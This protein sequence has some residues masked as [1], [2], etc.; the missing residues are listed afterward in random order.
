MIII[1]DKKDSLFLKVTLSL[2]FEVG[3]YCYT[4]AHKINIFAT[5]AKEKARILQPLYNDLKENQPKHLRNNN[6]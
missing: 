2:I 1:Y 4:Q 6:N 5:V 3:I